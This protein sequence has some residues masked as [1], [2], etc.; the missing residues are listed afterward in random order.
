MTI[1]NIVEMIVS[2]AG[3]SNKTTK[4]MAI[5]MGTYYGFFSPAILNYHMSY[6]PTVKAY[7][8]FFVDALFYINAIVNPIIYAW[9]NKDFNEA[10]KK[11]LYMKSGTHNRHIAVIS[12]GRIQRSNI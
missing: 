8:T 6:D 12:N 2:P 11:L 3:R 4:M 10:F 7:V 9:M 5:L 1:E